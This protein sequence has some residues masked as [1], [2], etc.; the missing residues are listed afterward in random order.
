[1][2][3]NDRGV[4][5]TNRN[6]RRRQR[7]RD[8]ILIAADHVFRRKGVNGA[9]V[10]DITDEADVA[11]GSFY[12]HFKAMDDVVAAVAEKTMRGLVERTRVLFANAERPELVPAIGSRTILRVLLP[13][14]AIRWLLERPYIFIAEFHKIV[15]PFIIE[16]DRAGISKGLLKP[17]AGQETWLRVF[18][19]I[20]IGELNHALLTDDIPGQEERTARIALAL[21][22]VK[23]SL[24][25]DL[26]E[27]SRKLVDAAGLGV[28]S[29][30]GGKA[31]AR[32]KPG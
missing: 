5:K 7:T 13:D 26:L 6:H 19:W 4:G 10:N 15:S 24:V 14:P 31:R 29:K 32:R 23:D 30:G 12:N 20:L 1:M 2:D 21:L 11:Y 22:G 25:P 8:A 17:V 3:E 9:S 27:K 16:S 28:S 18:P